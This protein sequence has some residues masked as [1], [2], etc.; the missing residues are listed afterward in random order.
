MRFRD[1]VTKRQRAVAYYGS[2]FVVTAFG[3]LSLVSIGLPILVVGVLLFALGPVRERRDVLWPPL[4]GVA[5]FVAAFLAIA[6]FQCTARSPGVSRCFSAFGWEAHGGMGVGLA[7]SLAA[8]LGAGLLLR[9]WIRR[10]GR[11]HA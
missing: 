10:R 8:A 7:L 11:L 3:F 5:G 4:I 1:D 2:A 9:G 6:P